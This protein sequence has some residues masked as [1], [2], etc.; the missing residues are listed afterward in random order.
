[1]GIYIHVPFC[2]SRCSCCH[3][4][5]HRW[6]PRLAERYADAVRS[7]IS[8]AAGHVDR[9]RTVDS[10][11]FGGGTPSLLR[12]GLVSRTLAAIG[13]WFDIAD[14]CEVSIEANPET[15]TREK[16]ESY[17]RLGINRVSVGV[18]SFVE[19]ELRGVGRRHSAGQAKECISV[20]RRAGFLN[21]NLDL[22]LGLPGQTRRR[23]KHTVETAMR[24]A[25]SHVS[26][27]MLDI[28]D[29]KARLHREVRSGQ[30]V[31]PDDDLIADLYAESIEWL[32]GAGLLQY[33]ISNFADPGRECRHNLKYW[34]C[35]PVLGFGVS[36]HSFDG[37]ARIANVSSL[38]DYLRSVEAGR[39]PE[40]TRTHLDA[41]QALEET[42]F[43]G[44]RLNRG[45]DLNELKARD[46]KGI[47]AEFESVLDE[48]SRRGLVENVGRTVRLTGRGRL[49]ANE[50]FSSLLR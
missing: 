2:V 14:G 12:T 33:E 44:L 31:L 23:W 36:S 49:L 24:I 45:V 38:Q 28:D 13:R 20:L 27:Y 40:E 39:S 46:G 15:I 21:I 3:F 1:M 29:P 9:K 19:D 41:R 30:C 48:M 37:A 32:S 35:R 22:M 5:T 6:S 43:L 7:E 11:Y 50:V 25:P 16:A 4:V 47:L 17:L 18:Q 34:T 10:I 42:L 26:V 8:M